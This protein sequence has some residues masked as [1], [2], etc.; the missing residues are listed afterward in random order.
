MNEKR[1]RKKQG[2][3]IYNI[4]SIERKMKGKNEK[5]KS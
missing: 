4:K 5:K 1:M 2:N 3:I